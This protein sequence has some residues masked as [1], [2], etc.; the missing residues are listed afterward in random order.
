[1]PNSQMPLSDFNKNLH[2]SRPKNTIFITYFPLN[3]KLITREGIGSNFTI[4]CLPADVRR[5]DQS[6]DNQKIVTPEYLFVISRRNIL[7]IFRPI[8]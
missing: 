7:G 8:V 1:M 2:I 6:S 5:C 4:H 3:R